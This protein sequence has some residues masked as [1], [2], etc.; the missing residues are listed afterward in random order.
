MKHKRGDTFEHVTYFP[1]VETETSD[2]VGWVPTCQLRT[3][4]GVLISDVVTAWVDPLT[5]LHISLEVADTS[6]WPVGP[7]VFDIQF[8]RESDSTIISTSTKV[9][10]II[11]DV[12]RP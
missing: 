5:A 8:T 6:T 1:D 2:F 11:E 10:H 4:Q 9:L 3:M 12:T 7:A